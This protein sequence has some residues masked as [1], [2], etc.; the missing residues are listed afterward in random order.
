MSIDDLNARI[1][2]TE[3]IAIG[4]SL[5]GQWTEADDEALSALYDERRRLHDML[6]SLTVRQLDGFACVECN[7]EPRVMVPVGFGPRGQ[8][9]ACADRHESASEGGDSHE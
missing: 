6:R 2:Q 5:C 4:K 1:A 7:A 9:F 8:V 3:R